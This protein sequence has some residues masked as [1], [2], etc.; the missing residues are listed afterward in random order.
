MSEA[1]EPDN[2]I[3][4]FDAMLSFAEVTHGV[5]WQGAAPEMNIESGWALVP[6]LMATMATAPSAAFVYALTKTPLGVMPLVPTRWKPG[7]TKREK[8]PST[9]RR[10]EGCF[11]L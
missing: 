7:R 4:G 9:Q 5:R 1:R 6:L 10:F 2:G 3:A 8:F 11:V